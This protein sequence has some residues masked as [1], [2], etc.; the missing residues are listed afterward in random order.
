M[1]PC[2]KLLTQVPM[3]YITHLVLQ[4][5]LAILGR[6]L[7]RF[8]SSTTTKRAT[9]HVAQRCNRGHPVA[10]LFSTACKTKTKLTLC[11]VVLRIV[12]TD[13]FCMFNEYKVYV[14]VMLILAVLFP[15]SRVRI[16]ECCCMIYG[17]KLN[18][19]VSGSDSHK[20]F[21]DSKSFD[22]HSLRPKFN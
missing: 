1:K 3:I 15:I 11:C 6:P 9:K 13:I 7:T 17:L 22:D 5:P 2:C 10:N 8:V 12:D 20:R 14:A 16:H 19:R 18:Q 4:I 21:H